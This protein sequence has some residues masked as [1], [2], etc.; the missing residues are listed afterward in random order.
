[1]KKLHYLV[2]NFI[3]CSIV[4][5]SCRKANIV[6]GVVSANK[7]IVLGSCIAIKEASLPVICFESVE[8]ESRCPLGAVCVW[9]GYAAVKLGIKNDAGITQHFSLAISAANIHYP[10]PPNDT[11]INGYH[12]KMID[13]LPYPSIILPSQE[14]PKVE[15][16][17]TQ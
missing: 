6:T 15:L 1:M 2:Y 13:L 3:F 14:A 10:F 4:F 16:Q 9:A 5:C 7:T 12:I 11:T 17:I 8:S